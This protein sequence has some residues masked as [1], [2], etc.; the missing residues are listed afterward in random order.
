MLRVSDTGAGIP[1]DELPRLF[2]RFHRVAGARGPHASR[3]AASGWRWCRSWSG[4]TAARS[5]SRARSGAGSTFTRH[6]PVRQRPPAGGSASDA[7]RTVSLDAPSR[8]QAYV[9]EALRWLP[10][11]SRREETRR[12][13]D[14][15]IGHRGACRRRRRRA[16]ILLADDNADMRD[17][18]RR[19]LAATGYEVE[20]VG[21]GEAALAAARRRP[22]DLVLS[23]VMMPRLDGFG[24]LEALRADEALRDVPVILLS[25]RA[26]EEARVDGLKAGADDYLIKPFSARELLARVGANLATAKLAARQWRRFAGQRNAGRAR[27]GTDPRARQHLAAVA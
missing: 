5:R 27:G 15:R 20:A 2:E 16:R 8:P 3:A 18:V 25:A 24:L 9:E 13:C 7:A 19:L 6:A 1:A 11:V 22:P 23:D 4:C 12:P 17:Y 14:D 10:D 26:G 21:D